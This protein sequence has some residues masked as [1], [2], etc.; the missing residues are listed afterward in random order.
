MRKLP[1]LLLAV[2]LVLNASMLAGVLYTEREA[3]RMAD[4]AVRPVEVSEA[5]SL[6]PVQ[7]EAFT[8]LQASLQERR[9]MFREY[10]EPVQ[11]AMTEALLE[12]SFDRESYRKVI[13]K[14]QEVREEYFLQIGEE[15]HAFLQTLSPEQRAMFKDL[16]RERSFLRRFIGSKTKLRSASAG[17]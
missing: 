9:Q 14:R 2:S 1:W 3:S 6:T 8:T 7:F 16:A 13:S 5:L 12:D 17:R 15:L 10:M 11:R 4:P